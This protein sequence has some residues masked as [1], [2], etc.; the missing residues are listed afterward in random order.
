MP[1]E[2]RLSALYESIQSAI[3]YQIMFLQVEWMSFLLLCI[4]SNMS[5]KKTKEKHTCA[6]WFGTVF[7]HFPKS[8]PVMIA[9][10]PPNVF[11]FHFIHHAITVH[12][13]MGGTGATLTTVGLIDPTEIWKNILSRIQFMGIF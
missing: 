5:I 4:W 7:L 10:T 11:S 1:H 8:P 2:K 9:A 3:T 6:R 12:F 13:A